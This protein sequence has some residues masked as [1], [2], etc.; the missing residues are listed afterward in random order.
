M[1]NIFKVLFLSLILVSTSCN[2]YLDVNTDPNNPSDAS[3]DLMLPGA[4]SSMMVTFGGDYN[5]LGGFWTQFYTQS[6]DAGQYEDYDE[7]NVPTDK[8]DGHWQ[9]AYAGGL[10]D[11]EIIR[12]KALQSGDNG[13]YLIAT[14]MQAYAFQMLAD[15]YN[16][17][18]FSEA[19]QGSDNY[20][21]K[22]DEG[23][24]IYPALLA[25]IDE[26]VALVNSGGIGEDPG[27]SDI[28]LGGDIDEWIRFA[29]T[30]KL[31]MYLR[32][33]YT[34]SADAAKVNA[35]LTED[36]FITR[37]IAFADFG[38]E[39]GK[40]NPYYEIQ[41]SRLG[42]V[43][44]RASLSLLQMLLDV[45]DNRIDGIY[46]PGSGGHNAK[47]QG[48]FANRDIPN[49]ELSRPSIGPTDPVYFMMVAEKHF[50]VAEALVR[51]AGGSGAKA[52]YEAGIE[53]SFAMHGASGA[54]ALYGVSGAYEYVPTGNVETDIEPIMTQKW[55]ALANF[56]NLE[57]FFERNRTQ[58]PPFQAAADQ[59]TAGDIGELTYSFASVLSAG[60]SP[61]RLP[62]PDREV[63]RN[64][65]A[66][67]QIAQAIGVK[68]WWDQK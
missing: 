36:N 24:D 10:N 45:G 52:A 48:D 25:R 47:I 55:I 38:A 30:L 26:A 32:M 64:T 29:N 34:S 65:N 31:K 57:A 67:A 61:R 46:D 13:Y 43:N 15:L 28:I 19:L 68:V 58:Y 49:G 6:P 60:K 14:L 23:K 66:P 16:E 17:I 2:E 59:G 5:T 54:A 50:L 63:Q 35:L 41:V 33:A 9:E 18:P 22:F 20:N 37:D 21:P 40:R 39:Q 44:C 11:L 8:F 3:I 62:V 12:D 4:Q 53:R 27:S 56:M 51:Y 42:D 1:K 7:Y